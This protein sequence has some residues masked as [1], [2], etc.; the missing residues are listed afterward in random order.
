[1]SVNIKEFNSQA[2]HFLNGLR[3]R[4]SGLRYTYRKSNYGGRLDEGFWFYGNDDY[5][6]ISFWTGMDWKN[7][8]PNISFFFYSNGEAQLQINVSDSDKKREFVELHVVQPLEMAYDGRR[9]IKRYGI[10]ESAGEEFLNLF[11]NGHNG[12]QADKAKIDAI[13]SS[14]GS[15][16]FANYDNGIGFIDSHEFRTRDLKVKKYL[17]LQDQEKREKHDALAKPSKIFS[18][19]ISGYQDIKKAYMENMPTDTQWIF[20]TGENGS[21]KTSVLKA[22]ATSLGYRLLDN[23]EIAE[24]PNFQ[25]SI[26]LHKGKDFN[27]YRR[28][29]NEGCNKRFPLV[30]A[31]VLFGPNRLISQKGKTKKGGLSKALKK[32]GMFLPLWDFEYRMLDIEEQFDQWRRERKKGK[33]ELE[34]RIYFIRTLLSKVVPGLYDIRFEETIRTGRGKAKIETKYI[35]RKDENSEE[36]EKYWQQL[37]SGTR[38][39]FAMVSEMLI[40]LYHFQKDII[41]PS[42]LR[43]IVIIDEIDLHLHPNAQRQLIIDLTDVFRNVQFIVA[44]HSPIPLLGAPQNSQFFRIEREL[45]TGIEI[46]DLNDIEVYHLLPNTI[47]TSDLFGM[48]SLFSRDQSSDKPIRTEQHYKEIKL[49][50]EV[51]M[52]LIEIANQLR[53]K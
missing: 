37:P 12:Q 33:D 18:I 47:L 48:N 34:K 49:N 35:I 52:E 41:D 44:T 26:N 32:E 13:I 1:M 31:L 53:N 20:L 22:I 2:Y 10:E 29:Q 39:V 45:E 30:S 4:Q 46:I 11:I 50:D 24:S 51:K 21:G 14:H 43:G 25:V 23:K 17:E 28:Q 15:T 27:S 40:R 36:E 7:R 6:C 3:E 5:F 16:F 42:E 38:S 8:T 19:L 9:F